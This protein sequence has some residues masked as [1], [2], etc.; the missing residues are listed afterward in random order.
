VNGLDAVHGGH[1]DVE[2][3][4]VGAELAG[5]G[6]RGASV[7]RLANHLNAGLGIEDHLEAGP[8][9]LLIIGDDHADAHVTEADLGST[10][11]TVQPLSG[12]G[13]PSR[14]TRALTSW[15]GRPRR[16]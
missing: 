5:E 4:H 11:L 10:A 3:A 7:G 2:Q 1:A 16:S 8:D 9:D 6:H 13:P 12:L 14:V 15:P